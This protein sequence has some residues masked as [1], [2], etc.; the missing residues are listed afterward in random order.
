MQGRFVSGVTGGETTQDSSSRR[1]R[2]P[3]LSR[4]GRKD[5]EAEKV[6]EERRL[7]PFVQRGTGRVV[8]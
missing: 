3:T 2:N 5:E 4:Q 1:S 7:P 8:R 6:V